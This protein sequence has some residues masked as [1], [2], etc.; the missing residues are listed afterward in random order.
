MLSYSVIIYLKNKSIKPP[1]LMFSWEVYEFFNPTKIG[2]SNEHP[3]LIYL[4]SH[5][6]HF[7]T[8][9]DALRLLRP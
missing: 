2:E 9:P 7:Y 8:S 1:L 5:G 4:L 6:N 3:L